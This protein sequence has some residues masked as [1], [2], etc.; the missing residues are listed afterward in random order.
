MAFNTRGVLLSGLRQ[1]DRAIADFDAAI[2]LQPNYS[3]AFENRGDAYQYKGELDRAIEDYDRAIEFEQKSSRVLY[4][5]AVAF[6]AKGD[7][8]R[9]AGEFQRAAEIASSPHAGLH[10]FLVQ[11]QRGADGS[12]ELAKLAG[13]YPATTWPDVL[14]Q[15][16]LDKAGED[17]VLAAAAVADT[18]ER[19]RREC[20]AHYYLGMGRLLKGDKSAAADLF[21]RGLAAP[22]VALCAVETRFALERLTAAR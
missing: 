22:P 12:A 7:L 20:E 10:V 16:F 11:K 9:A 1:F 14:V 19:A 2:R 8:E 3:N 15:F 13:R 21:H 17:A 6:A 18:D 4:N 5:R